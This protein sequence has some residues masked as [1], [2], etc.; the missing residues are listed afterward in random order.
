M[1]TLE[2]SMK[3]TPAYWLAGIAAA[4]I[5]A[6]FFVDDRYAKAADVTSAKTEL[7]QEMASQKTYTEQGFLKQRKS[8]LEDKVFELQAK[9][10]ERKISEVERKQLFRYKAELDDVTRELRK[11]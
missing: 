6:T 3:A 1:S 9:H 5:G 8:Q 2:N 11:K 4:I 10:D 7:K